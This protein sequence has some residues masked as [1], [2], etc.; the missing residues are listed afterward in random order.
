MKSQEYLI[1]V[2]TERKGKMREMKN[3]Y[4]FI[5]ALTIFCINCLVEIEAKGGGRAFGG[6]FRGSRRGGGRSGGSKIN[7]FITYS[8]VRP[9]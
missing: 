6:I 1:K 9:R 4:Y 3:Y 5:V 8:E 7:L 2:I